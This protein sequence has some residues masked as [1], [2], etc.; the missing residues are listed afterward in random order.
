M[1]EIQIED[2][3]CLAYQTDDDVEKIGIAQ[4]ITLG[5]SPLIHSWNECK[6]T[7]FLPCFQSHKTVK[8]YRN[9]ERK[10][11]DDTIWRDNLDM[12]H[13]VEYSDMFTPA[14]HQNTQKKKSK[15][16][17]GR[18]VKKGSNNEHVG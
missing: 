15:K 17:R 9:E 11:E 14:S 12:S 3:I 13:I 5:K 7:G 10:H 6:N 1:K 16:N 18:S 8:V 2:L 4:I